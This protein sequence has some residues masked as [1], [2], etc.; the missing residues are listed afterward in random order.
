[1]P[2]L[3]GMSLLPQSVAALE[4]SDIDPTLW[5]LLVVDDGSTDGTADWVREQGH[6]V[7]TVAGG[8]LGPG[9]ARNL[10]A[11]RAEG[12]LL[13][14]V[15]ADVCVHP[16][17]LRR[18]LRRFDREPR[19]GAA[20]G[21]YDA[22]PTAPGFVSQYRNLYHRY[23]HLRGAGDAETFWAGCGAVRRE[24]FASVGG[25][26]IE[27]FPRPQIEDIE[28][29]YRIRDAGWRIA[30]DP[31]IQSTHLKRWTFWSM[32]RT[33]LFDRGVPWMRLLLAEP[34]PESLNV[35]AAERLRTAGVGVAFGLFAVAAVTAD[36]LAVWAALT[37]LLAVTLSNPRLFRWFAEH[38]G[39]AF[40]AGVVPF[41]LLFHFI[42]GWSVVIAAVGHAAS[43]VTPGEA[44]PT[45]EDGADPSAGSLTTASARPAGS[46]DDA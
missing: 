1:M 7:V 8:P 30:L 26:D 24:V 12:D 28:L 16:D 5:R 40:A 31:D 37:L 17:A 34:R 25:F 4:G 44:R 38:R 2:V 10:G 3:N 21:A 9:A 11:A 33:D 29:G 42:S 35:G 13:L 6:D 23:V 32:V 20:F 27:R 15:D 19:L 18:F 14:F 22:R 45:F 41:H 39:W 36:L 43:R 46:P